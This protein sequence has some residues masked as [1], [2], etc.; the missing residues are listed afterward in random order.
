MCLDVDDL[1]GSQLCPGTP[2]SHPRDLMATKPLSLYAS[3]LGYQAQHAKSGCNE[4]I[5][6]AEDVIALPSLRKTRSESHMADYIILSILEP[7]TDENSEP[8][9]SLT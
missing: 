7:L 6:A 5:M 8:E 3:F 1:A 4:A 9:G 2:T